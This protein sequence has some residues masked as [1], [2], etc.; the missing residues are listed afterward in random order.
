MANVPFVRVNFTE[1]FNMKWLKRLL[2]LAA[3]VLLGAIA[4][5]LVGIYLYHG[6]P[7]WYRQR[8]QTTQQVLDA[9]NS[10]DQKLIDLFSW[11]ASAHA[12]EL[13]R[14][15]G[16]VK[17]SDQPI[18]P[19]TVTFSEDELNS[20]LTS[21]K[22]PQKSDLELRIG[23]YFADGRVIFQPDAII[24]AGQSPAINTLVS[25]E[26][27]PSIDAQGNLRLE[28][29]S[30][31]AGRLPL[32]ISALGSQL[33]RLQTLLQ[34]QLSRE[35]RE[36]AIDPAMAANSGALAASWLRLLL[37]A[38]NDSPADPVLII[39]FDMTHLN[40]GLPVTLTGIRVA[41]GQITLTMAP[42]PSDSRKELT[43]R[44]KQPWPA[45][46]E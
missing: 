19:K 31:R 14:V 42:V 33:D 18:G 13:R 45:A 2:C 35:Q 44:L 32:P 43:D 39:P 15:R 7:S 8:L 17:P 4:F 6:T 30:L 23:R 3:L 25:A 12:Q 1:L 29:G 41:E 22:T 5:C 38:L 36:A 21:W 37:S 24:L 40:S 10:A 20:F 26:F 11:A 34:Q 9:A 28:L 27:D 16:V 46:G